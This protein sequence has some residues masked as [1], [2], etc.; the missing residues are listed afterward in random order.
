VKL[1]LPETARAHILQALCDALERFNEQARRIVGIMFLGTPH[2]IND[3]SETVR[4]LD[5]TA[6]V[7][8]PFIR[9]AACN[10]R[11]AAALQVQALN[12]ITEEFEVYASFDD[13]THVISF[14]EDVPTTSVDQ[15]VRRTLLSAD[16]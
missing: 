14:S 7:E 8:S 4:T 6:R 15:V 12:R 2:A 3:P 9:I 1:Y 13:S 10:D 5:R 11:D 16:H